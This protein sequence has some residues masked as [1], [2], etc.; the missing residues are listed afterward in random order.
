MLLKTNQMFY[1]EV[2]G[3]QKPRL[4]PPCPHAQLKGYD[5][6]AAYTEGIQEEGGKVGTGKIKIHPVKKQLVGTGGSRP[7]K[8]NPSAT[9]LVERHKISSVFVWAPASP[10]S[11]SKLEIS[12][13][14]LLSEWVQALEHSYQRRI[15]EPKVQIPCELKLY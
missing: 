14:V 7:A 9:R 15:F 13:T 1:S 6:V 3:N 8:Q 12:V 5:S 4:S 11:L 10:T 2:G